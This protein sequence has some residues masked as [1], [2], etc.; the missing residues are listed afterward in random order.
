M[1]SFLFLLLQ[2]RFIQILK[3]RHIFRSGIVEILLINLMDAAVNNRLFHRLEA[4]L[5]AHH[6]LAQGKNKIRFQGDGIVLF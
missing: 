1:M 2:K 5:S 3:N 6:K 4:V